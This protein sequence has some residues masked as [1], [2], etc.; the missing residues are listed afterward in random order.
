MSP[1]NPQPPKS[2][3]GQSLGRL[4]KQGARAIHE[5]HEQ[6]EAEQRRAIANAKFPWSEVLWLLGLHSGLG[7]ILA[8][9]N[10][11]W[12]TVAWMLVIGISLYCTLLAAFID[13]SLLP[14]DWLC[15]AVW[16]AL[17][18]PWR[19][20]N[21]KLDLLLQRWI[22]SRFRHE[23]AIDFWRGVTKIF[24]FMALVGLDG[25]GLWAGYWVG[26]QVW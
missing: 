3:V 7:F 2:G 23:L 18:L 4:I 8:L 26:M 16:D 22:V 19:A 1:Q 9:L 15:A 10:G 6:S 13:G 21:H 25:L 14:D 11:D 20:T 5:W 17:S 12:A 24:S